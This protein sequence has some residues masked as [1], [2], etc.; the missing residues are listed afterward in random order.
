MAGIQ[1]PINPWAMMDDETANLIL[2]FHS[3]DLDDLED[4]SK[5]K[6]AAGKPSDADLAREMYRQE[7]LHSRVF[8]SDRSMTRSIAA[9]IQTDHPALAECQRQ[10]GIAQHDHQHARLLGG[11]GALPVARRVEAERLDDDTLSQLTEDY[12]VEHDPFSVAGP[13]NSGHNRVPFKPIETTCTVCGDVKLRFDC[14]RLGCQHHYCGDC[15]RGLFQACITD[16]SLFPPRCCRTKIELSSVVPYL[17][18]EI[19]AAFEAKKIEYETPNRT[20]CNAQTCSSFIPPSQIND[21][22]ATCARCGT[23]TC[24]ACKGQAHDGECPQNAETQ[25]VLSMAEANGWRRCHSCRR[26]V[27]LDLGCNH[28]TFVSFNPDISMLTTVDV[29]AGLNSATSVVQFGRHVNARSGPKTDCIVARSNSSTDVLMPTPPSRAPIESR[30]SPG[31]CAIIVIA[32]M[33]GTTTKSRTTVRCAMIT[34]LSTSGNARIVE[35][36]LAIVASRIVCEVFVGAVVS[37]CCS[38]CV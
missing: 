6:G 38:L 1:P 14:V 22:T 31:V 26:M 13:T 16:E 21:E 3:E 32:T 12:M 5:G 35:S 33:S 30:R 36:R 24:T 18:R 27:E 19:T 11:L 10:E 29:S 37:G 4:R 17:T 8:V 28:I 34:C 25:A 20:Y 23:A 9:A 2:Q 15:V 7:L